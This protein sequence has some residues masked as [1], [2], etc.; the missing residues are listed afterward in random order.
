MVP[1][2]KSSGKLPDDLFW[3]ALAIIGVAASIAGLILTL[4][5]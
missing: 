2:K 3:K 4:L 1:E 5:K